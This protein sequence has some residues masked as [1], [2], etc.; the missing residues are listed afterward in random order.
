MPFCCYTT[1]YSDP[2]IKGVYH[3]I[4]FKG[5]LIIGFVSIIDKTMKIK[6]HFEIGRE[7]SED[8]MLEILVENGYKKKYFDDQYDSDHKD[9]V[10]KIEEF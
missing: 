7:I 8:K 2:S 5:N 9:G 10:F 4:I 6:S 1:T 3:K